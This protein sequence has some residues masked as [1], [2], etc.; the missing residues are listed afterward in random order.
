MRAVLLLTCLAAA[1]ATPLRGQSR[2]IPSVIRDGLEIY[3]VKGAS[4]ATARWVKD[5]PI[6]D[7]SE[8]TRGLGLVENAYGRMVGYEV[9]DV[10]PLGKY[11][12]RT[13]LILLFE[14]GPLYFWFDCYLYKD[15][16]IITALLFNTKPDMILPAKMLTH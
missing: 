7:P 15:Q 13:Y 11:A 1:A 12:Q 5:S 9:L 3:K 8:L 4:A 16:W 6:T 2:E 14:K 10:I